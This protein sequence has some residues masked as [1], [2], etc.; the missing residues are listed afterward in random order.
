[1]V[2]KKLGTQMK[3]AAETITLD[4]DKAIDPSKEDET[5]IEKREIEQKIYSKNYIKSFNL[6][7]NQISTFKDNFT[8]NSVKLNK[9]C[10]LNI[11]GTN[12]NNKKFIIDNAEEGSKTIGQGRYLVIY[13]CK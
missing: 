2:I 13:H 3:I 10:L 6:K 7:I 4:I 8:N 11:G 5:I 9:I 12:G 1:M